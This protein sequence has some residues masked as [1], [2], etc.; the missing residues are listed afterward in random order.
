[1]STQSA[2]TRRI[3][4]PLYA[5]AGAGDLAYE[6]LRKLPA[7]A[8]ELRGRVAAL[9]PVVADAVTSAVADPAKRVD[10][11]RLRVIARRNAEVLRTPGRLAAHAGGRGLHRAGRPGREGRRR[12][13][14]GARAGRR[15]GAGGHG[16]RGQAG[17]GHHDRGHRR[18]RPGHRQEPG[19]GRQ[20]GPP[21][22]GQ[23]VTESALVPVPR[24]LR[25]DPGNGCLSFKP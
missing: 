11:E 4:N 24:G 15:R 13:L 21:H 7:K 25:A 1:M 10:V 16:V 22:R 14:Q 6:Q 3:P 5:A 20:E 8:L 12:P 19:E 23:A 2:N 9:R 18:R 17:A